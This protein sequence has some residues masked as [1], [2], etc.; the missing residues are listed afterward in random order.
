MRFNAFVECHYLVI[1]HCATH[2]SSDVQCTHTQVYPDSPAQA[3]MMVSAAMKVGVI[4]FC[5]LAARTQLSIFGQRSC[6]MHSCDTLCS[7]TN[8]LPS[9][10]HV[11]TTGRLLRRPGRGLPSQHTCQEVLPGAHGV[12]SWQLMFRLCLRRMFGLLVHM[13]SHE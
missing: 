4:N 2:E 13:H 10:C 12:C 9:T 6:D 1:V 7:F 3:E 8:T 11:N 5:L